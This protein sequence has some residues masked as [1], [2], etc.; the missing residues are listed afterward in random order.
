MLLLLCGMQR[1]E[2]S[3]MEICEVSLTKNPR[4]KNL[5]GGQKIPGKIL[6][7]IHPLLLVLFTDQSCHCM[8]SQVLMKLTDVHEGLVG[9]PAVTGFSESGPSD[10]ELET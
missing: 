1:H 5:T 8:S 9:F 4:E 7:K 6:K 3:K 2:V 10:F